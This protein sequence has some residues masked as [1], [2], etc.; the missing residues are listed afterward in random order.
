[1]VL[2]RRHKMGLR[3][4]LVCRVNSKVDDSKLDEFSRL[5]LKY[6]RNAIISRPFPV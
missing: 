5:R 4:K 1:M 3:N 2:H 6:D